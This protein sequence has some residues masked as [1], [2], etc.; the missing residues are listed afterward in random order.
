MMIPVSKFIEPRPS[1]APH[2]G[3]WGM[4][5]IMGIKLFIVIDDKKAERIA[6]LEAIKA[7]LV[8]PG[9]EELPFAP[10][11]GCE[12]FAYKNAQLMIHFA[13]NLEWA[14]HRL[15]F[16]SKLGLAFE[17]MVL[18]DLMFPEG[19]GHREQANGM[20]V[21]T[22][23]IEKGLP[24]VVCSDTHHH[25]LNYLNGVWPILSKA[26]PKGEIPVILDKK[27]WGRAVSEALRISA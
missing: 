11:E 9:D 8:Q 21:V 3:F 27:D 5:R 22:A 13:P 19:T 15:D 23:C 16:V 20:Q 18:T 14:I 25:D 26:H 6:A 1:V 10:I 17:I 4:E 2:L 7:A 24:V 12:Q